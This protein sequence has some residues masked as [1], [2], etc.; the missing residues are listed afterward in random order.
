MSESSHD[1]YNEFPEYRDIIHS[2]KTSDPHFKKLF[3][4]Y[5]DVV[6]SIHRAEQRIDKISEIEEEKLRKVRLRLKDEIFG[7]LSRKK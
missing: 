1:L 3:D 5:H 4:E 7:I 6:K 2:L